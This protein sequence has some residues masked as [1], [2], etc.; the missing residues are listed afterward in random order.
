[1][2]K[3]NWIYLTALLPFVVV[4]CLYEL[5]PLVIVVVNSF[6]PDV[7]TGFTLENYE[8]VFTKLLY[9]KAI[10][11]SIKIPNCTVKSISLVKITDIGSTNL[12]KYTLPKIAAL[13][14]KVEDIW[15]KQAEK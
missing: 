6:E 8:T 14:K 3:K 5:L 10:I 15:L 13:V 11:N 12:G 9:Q 2:K 7:G 1:M 4:T